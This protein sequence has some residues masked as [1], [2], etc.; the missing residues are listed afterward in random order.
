MTALKMATR[1]DVKTTALFLCDMQTRFVQAI[2]AFEAVE[3]TSQKLLKAAHILDV[4]VFTT[5]QAPKG[6]FA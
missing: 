1:L 6:A 5:E 4:P 2:H 3:A